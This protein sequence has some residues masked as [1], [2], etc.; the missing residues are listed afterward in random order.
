MIVWGSWRIQIQ[1]SLTFKDDSDG[2]LNIFVRRHVKEYLLNRRTPK[3][4][5]IKSF[6]MCKTVTNESDIASMKKKAT[7]L[8][9]ASTPSTDNEKNVN[10]FW[11]K[12]SYYVW[13]NSS[14]SELK[15]QSSE[16]LHEC[17]FRSMPRKWQ[18][19][20]Q[21]KVILGFDDDSDGLTPVHTL[22]N[23]PSL[24]LC[25]RVDNCSPRR[26]TRASFQCASLIIDAL[27]PRHM[28]ACLSW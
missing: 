24:A 14:T 20:S 15:S 10:R 8:R 5:T 2:Y 25:A 17:S 4:Q 21:I 19:S 9:L 6:K 12:K 27:T 16:W 23:V 18:D 22:S 11:E 13:R 26:R 28:P 3:T 1:Y 7:A